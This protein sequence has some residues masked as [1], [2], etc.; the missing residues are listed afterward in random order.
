MSDDKQ[1]VADVAPLEESSGGALGGY[2]ATSLGR[3]Q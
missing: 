3:A 1:P 2:V